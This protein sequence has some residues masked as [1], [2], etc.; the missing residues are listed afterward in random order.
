MMASVE[1]TAKTNVPKFEAK[2]L[3]TQ[4][5]LLPLKPSS[6][7]TRNLPIFDNAHA[8]KNRKA[9]SKYFPGSPSVGFYLSET[10]WLL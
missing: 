9:I 6:K 4:L 1:R 3:A 7:A 2:W 5:P 8:N 10:T